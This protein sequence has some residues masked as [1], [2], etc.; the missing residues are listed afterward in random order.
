MNWTAA[1]LFAAVLTSAAAAAEAQTTAPQARIET[2][3][4]TITIALDAAR[5]PRTVANFIAY[6]REGHFDGT[7]VYRVEP[8]FVIQMGSFEAD[9]GARGVDAPIALETASGLTNVRGS[10]AMARQTNPASATAEFFIDLAA[11]PNLDPAPAAAPN[12]TGY[13]VF[14]HVTG[15]MDVVD[16]IAA[17]PLGGIGPFPPRATPATPI[18]VKKVTVSGAGR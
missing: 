15:G 16:R 4:G 9:G 18:M 1:V 12:T 5:A 17:T 6:A 14:G 13:A 10:V 7:I 11:K 3:L 2:S 8:G